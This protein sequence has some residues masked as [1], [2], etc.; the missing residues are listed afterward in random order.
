MPLPAVDWSD[1]LNRKLLAWWHATDRGALAVDLTGRRSQRPVM[2]SVGNILG[3]ETR[4]CVNGQAARLHNNVAAYP[5]SA[6]VVLPRAAHSIIFTGAF[7]GAAGSVWSA[8]RDSRDIGLYITGSP[9]RWYFHTGGLWLVD[10]TQTVPN[11]IDNGWHVAMTILADA[12]AASRKGY[13]NGQFIGS[14]NCNSW[15]GPAGERTVYMGGDAYSQPWAG[16]WQ[17][18]AYFDGV[19]TAKEIAE[20][21]R[22]WK[23]GYAPRQ[24]PMRFAAASAGGGGGACYWPVETVSVCSGAPLGYQRLGVNTVQTLPFVPGANALLLSAE[25]ADIRYTIDGT[26]PTSSS[27]CLISAS[28]PPVYYSGPIDRLRFIGV[29]AGAFLNALYR[30]V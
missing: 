4:R 17:S 9:L 20:H 7:L 10:G 29:S 11:S 3:Q 1:P 21:Y 12:S 2:N 8:F 22:R 16:L 27:G 14:D 18:V 30:C 26:D 13:V 5:F 23:T 25:V 28:G 19:L 24:H 6:T 15:T